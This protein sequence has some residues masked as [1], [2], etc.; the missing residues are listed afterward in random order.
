MS[1]VASMTEPPP[2][3]TRRSAFASRAAAAPAMTSVRGEWEAMASNVPT[4]RGPSSAA[5]SCSRTR[6]AAERAGGH[7]EEALC[8]VALRQFS[9]GLVRRAVRR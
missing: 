8:V 2:K 6:R 7:Q 9:D 1:L 5:K 3:A 4:Q